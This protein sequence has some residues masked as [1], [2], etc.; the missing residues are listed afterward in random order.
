M[1]QLGQQRRTPS[2]ETH[3]DSH[4]AELCVHTW[5]WDISGLVPSPPRRLRDEP[6]SSGITESNLLGSDRETEVGEL[7]AV[8]EQVQGGPHFFLGALSLQGTLLSP[9]GKGISHGTWDI[10]GT[11][12]G[13][14]HLSPRL[15]ARPQWT[16]CAP[17]MELPAFDPMGVKNQTS[18]QFS[19]QL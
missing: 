16:P 3:R 11:S 1:G 6:V 14:A 5:A 19:A 10:A 17:R 13:Q 12:E 2:P 4:R 7:L 15:L 18:G 9:V 8:T